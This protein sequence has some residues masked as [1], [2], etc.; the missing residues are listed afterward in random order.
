MTEQNRR[1]VLRAAVLTPLTVDLA[2]DVERM[3]A[4]CAA[5]LHGGC[6]GVVLFGTTG[7]GPAFSVDERIAA[8]EAVLE[9]GVPA[10]RMMVGTGCTALPDT[11]HLTRHAAASGCAGA[12]IAPP[13]FFKSVADDGVFRAFAEVID[14]TDRADLPIHLY[15]IPQLT[16]VRLSHEVIDRLVSGYPGVVAGVKDSSADWPRT[17]QLIRRFGALEILVGNE[18]DITQALTAGGAGTTCGLANML[19][20]LLRALCDAPGSPRA[21]QNQATID[22]VVGPLLTCPVVAALKS[23]MAVTSGDPAW[24]RLRP[25]LTAL[26]EADEGRLIAALPPEA[27]PHRPPDGTPGEPPP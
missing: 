23:L 17:L 7:E 13:F 14:K 18:A 11:V 8:V 3:A 20:G 6:D 22:A 26:G 15:N 16:G 1:A 27:L 5:L 12:L 19:P 21:A 25:P 9:R 24:H 10:D 2:V 4:H